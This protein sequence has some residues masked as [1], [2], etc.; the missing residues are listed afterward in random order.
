MI[1]W[2]IVTLVIMYIMIFALGIE[3]KHQYQ[4]PG[5]GTVVTKFHGKGFANKKAYDAADLRFPEIEPFG[6]FIMTKE[7][8]IAGQQIG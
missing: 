6:S 2:F 8:K 1:Y 4:E 5:I 7:V 3:G